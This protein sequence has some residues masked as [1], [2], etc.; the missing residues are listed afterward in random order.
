M[1]HPALPHPITSCLADAVILTRPEPDPGAQWGRQVERDDN[2]TPQLAVGAAVGAAPTCSSSEASR[3][4]THG[5]CGCPNPLSLR[6]CH[7]SPSPH[8]LSA[9]RQTVDEGNCQF[10]CAET[11]CVRCVER[12]GTQVTLDTS[13]C[14]DDSKAISWAC[15]IETKIPNVD[16]PSYPITGT[17][18]PVVSCITSVDNN[19]IVTGSTNLQKCNDALRVTFKVPPEATSIT[20]QTHD[21]VARG[22]KAFGAT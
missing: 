5:S 9:P 15:C 17:I 12:S 18:C 6:L 7:P 19:V 14:K 16:N 11:S 2:E 3:A 1:T 10:S 4:A 8:T 22:T 13:E 20:I 21:G